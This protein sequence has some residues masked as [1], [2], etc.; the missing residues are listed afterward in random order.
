[1]PFEKSKRLKFISVKVLYFRLHPFSV[2]MGSGK[3]PLDISG[4]HSI[5]CR[6]QSSK[7]SDC[8]EEDTLRS[9]VISHRTN[10]HSFR[11]V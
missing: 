7:S 3:A 6:R 4:A 5:S 9:P 8:T 11:V 2:W 1:M 10:R